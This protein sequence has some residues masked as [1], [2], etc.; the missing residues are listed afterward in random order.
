MMF[1]V[2][3]VRGVICV[4]EQIRRDPGL[5]L[6][7]R[8]LFVVR[9]VKLFQRGDLRCNFCQLVMFALEEVH[10]VLLK[11]AI[12]LV[13]FQL[14]LCARQPEAIRDESMCTVSTVP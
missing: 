11:A 14:F 7:G 10:V 2:F 1:W 9:E 13:G 12:C 4:E 5:L 3:W 6:G 8:G